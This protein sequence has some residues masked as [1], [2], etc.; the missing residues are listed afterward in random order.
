MDTDSL[1]WQITDEENRRGRS[2]DNEEI[3]GDV[4]VEEEEEEEE[5][6]AWEEEDDVTT[7]EGSP[8]FRDDFVDESSKKRFNRGYSLGSR[9]VKASPCRIQ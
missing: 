8:I 1:S 7:V 2:E 3:L 5:G 4:S 9:N 6:R